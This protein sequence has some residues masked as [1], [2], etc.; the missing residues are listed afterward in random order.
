MEDGSSDAGQEWGTS[1]SSVFCVTADFAMQN[2]ILQ[3]GLRLA[4]PDGRQICQLSCWVLRCSAC[5]NVTKVRSVRLS[6]CA[7]TELGTVCTTRRG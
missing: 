5:F 3:M 7:C 6:L 1:Q 4:A 2:I